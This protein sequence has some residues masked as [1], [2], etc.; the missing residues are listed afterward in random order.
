MPIIVLYAILLILIIIIFCKVFMAVLEICAAI[1]STI[2]EGWEKAFKK[3]GNEKPVPDAPQANEKY[4]TVQT[5]S[6]SHL[7]VP[8]IFGISGKCEICGNDFLPVRSSSENY[9]NKV[10]MDFYG[11]SRTKLLC[12]K[13]RQLMLED[14]NCSLK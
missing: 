8:L 11:K 10:D 13:C 14:R 12:R 5:P 1:A 7:P 9:L 3:R 4:A 6:A 2:K